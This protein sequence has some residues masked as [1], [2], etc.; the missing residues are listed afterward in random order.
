M[1]ELVACGQGH[2]PLPFPDKLM[3]AFEESSEWEEPVIDHLKR[4]WGYGSIGEEQSEG[5]LYCGE[6]GKGK[7]AVPVYV[8]YH[9]DFPC[10]DGRE[11]VLVEVKAFSHEL[12]VRA[13]RFGVASTFSEYTWQ[14]GVMCA[15]YMLPGRWI[16]ADKSSSKER[17]EL[18]YE[19]AI[20]LPTISDIWKRAQKI[21]K[22]IIG[23]DIV[24]SGRKCPEEDY[25]P[26]R[27]THLRPETQ[28]IVV[29]E[30]RREREFNDLVFDYLEAKK[31]EEIHKKI[32]EESRDTYL[33]LFGRDKKATS[34]MYTVTRC[35]S[36][37][38]TYDYSR[39][40]KDMREAGLDPETYK[41]DVP[42]SYIRVR[43]KAKL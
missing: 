12:F 14:L 15:G 26:C 40:F 30:S 18:Y 28:S 23:P 8:R 13:Q 43:Q 31:E 22:Q 3:M 16:V 27:F 32:R 25:W 24:Q 1:W 37:N 10:F 20:D 36:H 11:Q 6:V 41:K 19:D 39:M 35:D 34:D 33:E 29:I 38:S 42:Y 2:Q 7:L 4:E 17:P 9:P 21:G 5:E